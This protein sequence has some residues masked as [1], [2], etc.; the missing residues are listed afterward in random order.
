MDFFFLLYTVNF[1]FTLNKKQSSCLIYTVNDYPLNAQI[2]ILVHINISLYT[3]YLLPQ[4]SL[5]LAVAVG[6]GG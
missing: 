6:Y 2:S 3:F 5:L 1:N 4:L